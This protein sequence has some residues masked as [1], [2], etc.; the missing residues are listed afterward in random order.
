MGWILWGIFLMIPAMRHPKVPPNTEL[1]GGRTILGLVA[2][3]IFVLT[4]TPTPFYN[5]SLMHFLHVDP[6]SALH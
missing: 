4:F 3:A 5:S 2:L 1:S 6:F